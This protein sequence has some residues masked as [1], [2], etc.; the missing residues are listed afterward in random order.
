M[1]SFLGQ[2][3]HIKGRVNKTKHFLN[4]VAKSHSREI[5]QINFVLVSDDE[6]L[7]INVSSLNH[8]Y[9]T[10]IITF[11]YSE[12]RKIDAEI[13]IST[14]RVM[15]NAK[16]FNSTF[17]DEL[18]RVVVHGLLHIIGFKDF[19]I[20]QKSEMRHQENTL[21]HEYK[22]MFHEEQSIQ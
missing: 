2:I 1:I 21:I 4:W 20:E 19:T 15:S 12:G 3:K 11:D 18:L 6:L 13:Y 5:Q 8:D 14:D 22:K 9:Y 16:E 10:D 17:E 7:D